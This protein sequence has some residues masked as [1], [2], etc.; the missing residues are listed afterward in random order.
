MHVVNESS[1]VFRLSFEGGT[2]L[3][4]GKERAREENGCK[5]GEVETS[6]DSA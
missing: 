3:M 1:A 2:G 6:Y 4:Q 5:Y